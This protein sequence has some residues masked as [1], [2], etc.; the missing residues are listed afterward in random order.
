MALWSNS[1]LNT[2]RVSLAFSN[3]VYNEVV[4]ITRRKYGLWYAIMGKMEVGAFVDG[5]LTFKEIKEITGYKFE[6]NF[7]GKVPTIQKVGKGSPEL[8]RVS[9]SY[10]ANIW[11]GYQFDLC[12][13]WYKH[14]IP[15]SDY[16]QIRGNEIKTKGMLEEIVD[17]VVEGL[18]TQ[19]ADDMHA[20]SNQTETSLAGIPFIIDDNTDYAFDRSDSANAKFESQVDDAASAQLTKHMLGINQNKCI[21]GGGIPTL[22]IA[23]IERYTD[24][25]DIVQESVRAVADPLWDEFGGRWVR[26]GNTVYVMD[27]RA[28][29]NTV[30]HMTP[31]EWFLIRNATPINTEGIVLDPTIIAGYVLPVHL[32]LG[33]GCRR[34]S[35]Q[36]KI[37]N[38]L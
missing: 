11:G 28:L 23:D 20:N 26:Y 10:D 7:R 17:Y 29:A 21:D 5:R 27:N 4:S 9:Y 33:V 35:A 6:V 34:P 8:Q 14:P 25:Q 37:T 31:S 19:I 15:K 3:M 38:L 32:Y 36:G 1:S 2:N 24:I 30:F 18:D 16:D 22:G 13:Y 12:Q